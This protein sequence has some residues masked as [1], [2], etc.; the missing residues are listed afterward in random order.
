MF[1]FFFGGGGGGRDNWSFR[2]IVAFSAR[3]ARG[4]AYSSSL[5]QPQ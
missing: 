5:G 3:P 1:F 2:M 4:V